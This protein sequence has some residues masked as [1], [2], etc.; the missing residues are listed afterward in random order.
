MRT[1]ILATDIYT[2]GGIAR[3]TQTFASVLADLLGSNNV[4]ILA[5]LA[6]GEPS[7]LHA[8]YRLV[9]PVSD[10]LTVMAKI[11]FA[12][13]ALA[14]AR[15]KYDL[16]VCSHLRLAPVAAAIHLVF[17]T[18]FWV[19]C[20]GTEVWG[21]LSFSNRVAI[22]K[23]ELLL[24]IS[25]FTAEKLSEVHKIPQGRMFIL[26]NAIPDGLEKLLTWPADRGGSRARVSYREPVLLSVGSLARAH[27]YKGF[28]T[29]LHALPMVLKRTPDLRYVIVGEGDDRPRLEKL[30]AELHL[31]GHVKFTGTVS[32]EELAQYYRSCD[33]FVLPSRAV[34]RNG[35]WEGEG[36]GRVYVEAAL[37]AKPVV[38]SLGGGAA[39]AVLPEK[40]GLLVE[41]SSAEQT[42]SAIIQL[43]ESPA[44]A[45]EMGHAGRKWAKENFTEDA[46]RKSLRGLL[47][48]NGVEEPRG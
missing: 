48:A 25:R 21:S 1:L 2:R 40:T 26:H 24:P 41:P 11:Q 42:G 13:K 6:Y 10:R 36:F 5:L 27:A 34:A 29:V 46:L 8:R 19:V 17:R 38:G 35:N 28:D 22:R 37:A 45:I 14:L 39:E 31:D 15:H 23:S 18:P 43:L 20:H 9:G 16:M 47:R 33:V 7:D 44:A 12:L 32:D 3:Y 4:D 30:A